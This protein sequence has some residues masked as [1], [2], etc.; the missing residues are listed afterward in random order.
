MLGAGMGPP[1]AAPTDSELQSSR[2]PH[3]GRAGTQAGHGTQW[4]TSEQRLGG[5]CGARLQRFPFKFLLIYLFLEREEGREKERE[6]NIH[7]LLL[8]HTPTDES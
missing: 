1:R 5:Q 3:L 2:T 6:R 8:I 7:W 4:Q